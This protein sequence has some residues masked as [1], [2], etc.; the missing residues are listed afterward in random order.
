MG[1]SLEAGILFF[2]GVQNFL[3]VRSFFCE[4]GDFCEICDFGDTLKIY[5]LWETHGFHDHCSGTGYAT[6]CQAVRKNFIVYSLFC[7]FIII[8]NISFIVLLSCLYLKSAVLPFV[9][10]PPHPTRVEWEG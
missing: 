4:F 6:G 9:H 8:S 10:S 2:L 7:I 1:V 3:G 5:E